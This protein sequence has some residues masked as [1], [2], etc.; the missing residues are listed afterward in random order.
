[1]S[2]E[3]TNSGSTGAQALTVSE[4]ASALVALD[5]VEEHAEAPGR[6]E[7]PAPAP[8]PAE[9][10]ESES[11]ADDEPEGEEDEVETD[12]ES[13]DE[14]PPQPRTRTLKYGDEELEVTEEELEKGYLR[15]SDYTRKTQQL[16]EQRKAAEQELAAV[17]AERE[18]YA[19]YLSQ[20]AAIADE[21]TAQEPD[22]DTIRRDH[23]DEYPVLWADWQRQQE[24]RKAVHAERQRVQE[25]LLR[26]QHA[27][28]EA[29]LS[30]QKGHLLE[31]IPAW[32]DEAVASREKAELIGF[33]KN[34]GYTDEELAGV[35][36]HRVLVLLRKAMLH[37]KA[38]QA[39]PV[40]RER[41]EKVRTAAPGPA[42]SSRPPVKPITRER[43]RLAKTGRVED[44]ARVLELMDG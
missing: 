9:E 24:Q 17:R 19:Q 11:P 32:K 31:K 1:M 6:N 4:A 42:A 36:D 38:E 23:P 7:T 29:Y 21:S 18:Q 13:D 37:D 26:D 16:A 8:A 40:V 41:I 2:H 34:H 5:S 27:Q 10:V 14:Q 28:F 15:T 3:A 33:A 30:E 12:E 43:Q 20:L 39:K 35:T 25:Q 22:W 44:A